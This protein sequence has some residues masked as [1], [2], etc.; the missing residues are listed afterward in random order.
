MS[1]E[2]LGLLDSEDVVELL[3]SLIRGQS[4]RLDLVLVGLLVEGQTVTSDGSINGRA[5]VSVFFDNITAL[6]IDLDALAR[7]VHL[8]ENLDTLSLDL[9]ESTLLVLSF[10]KTDLFGTLSVL[11]FKITLALNEGRLQKVKSLVLDAFDL[12]FTSVPLTML[13]LFHQSAAQGEASLVR[14]G[15]ECVLESFVLAHLLNEVH[16]DHGGRKATTELVVR[17]VENLWDVLRVNGVLRRVGVGLGLG[18]SEDGLHFS[19]LGAG[20]GLWN[21]G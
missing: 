16:L 21:L 6:G 3:K 5:E 9:G 12:I 14:S 17:N 13:L 15:R 19:C 1:V 18:F 8:T 20:L 10:L 11:L 7:F 2:N 4:L